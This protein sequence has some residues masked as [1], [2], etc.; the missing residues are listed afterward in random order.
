[1]VSE[2]VFIGLQSDFIENKT[3]FIGSS[4]HRVDR[5]VT[6]FEVVRKWL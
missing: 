4:L 2:K 6:R 3:G 5:Y 1:M